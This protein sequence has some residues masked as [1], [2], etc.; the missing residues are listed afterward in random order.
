MEVALEQ[1]EEKGWLGVRL[2]TG[3][4]IPQG[5]YLG[6]MFGQVLG[7]EFSQRWLYGS[8][9]RICEILLYLLRSLDVNRPLVLQNG[10][11]EP[12]RTGSRA[13]ADAGMVLDIIGGKLV[14]RSDNVI[15]GW[16]LQRGHER[17]PV[18]LS[19]HVLPVKLG[20]ILD[21]APREGMLLDRDGSSTHVFV[22]SIGMDNQDV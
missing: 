8:H 5:L 9:I 11:L 10:L 22:G 12:M 7:Q 4:P 6:S 17:K 15:P 1:A 16:I 21:I 20:S 18:D 2:E 14:I 3:V 19:A 13:L